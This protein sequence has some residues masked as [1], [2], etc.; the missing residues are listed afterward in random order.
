MVA[1]SNPVAPT[2]SYRFDLPRS[3]RPDARLWLIP[4]LL[5]A[6]GPAFASAADRTERGPRENDA[7]ARPHERACGSTLAV[8][9]PSSA[10]DTLFTRWYNDAQNDSGYY[11]VEVSGGDTLSLYLQW[12]KDV[13]PHLRIWGPTG[14]TAINSSLR[15]W[16]INRLVVQNAHEM[17]ETPADIT[18]QGAN[19]R[20]EHIELVRLFETPD[21]ICWE[22]RWQYVKAVGKRDTIG[23]VRKTMVRRREPYFLVRYDL[24]WL[25]GAQDS[26]RFVW[27]NQPRAGFEG[28]RNDVGFA[29]GFGL[30]TRQKAF[31]AAALGYFA[32]MLDIGNPLAAGVD[33]V[34]GGKPSYM[35]P[36]LRV[37]FGSGE[38]SF[39]AGF[40][41]FNPE[42]GIVPNEFAWIDSKGAGEPSL[43]FDSPKIAVDTTKVIDGGFRNFIA[44][45]GP[46][47]FVPGQTRSF[48][49]A[50]GRASMPDGLPPV[51]PDVVW[52]DGSIS[53]CPTARRQ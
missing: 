18:V 50:I 51:A 28:S 43:D 45:S 23:V 12:I 2:I 33:T 52:F 39:A 20:I 53:S 1:G 31:D 44:R 5:L 17:S 21:S 25:N 37:D 10:R 22:E 3:R 36:E 7:H 40:V 14:G 13:N 19:S 15:L 34:A 29:P 32:F 11:F 38:R 26:V 47:K 48:E 27:S 9:S 41:C 8:D 46:V 30:V 49:Y 16:R 24:T 35:S 42:A 4:F 6:L